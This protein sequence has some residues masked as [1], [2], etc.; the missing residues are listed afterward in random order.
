MEGINNSELVRRLLEIPV[1]REINNVLRNTTRPV[2]WKLAEQISQ[3]VAGSGIQSVRPTKAD[4]EEFAQACRIAELAV[5][6]QS[7]LGPVRGITNVRLLT[8][9]QWTE[10]NVNALKP[11]VE[12]LASRLSASAS[13][14]TPSPVQPVMDAIGPLVMGAQF[15]LTFGYL[16]HKALGTWDFGLPLEATRSVKGQMGQLNFNFSNIVRLEEELEIDPRQFRMWLALHDVTHELLFQAVNWAGPYFNS[17]VETYIDAAQVD[18]SELVAKVQ[19]FSDP[20]QLASLLQRPEDLL[21]ML[22]SP[23]QQ[24]VAERI[25]CFLSL[26]EGYSDWILKRGGLSLVQSFDRIR[27]GMSRRMAER[28]SPEKM[29]E[30]LFGLDLSNRNRRAGERFVGAIAEAGRLEVLWT[31]VENL[32]SADELS[33]PERWISRVGVA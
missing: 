14:D 30:K 20:Q 33:Q 3:A 31:K 19:S 10:L 23:I 1:I 5:V 27:E 21:P 18:A 15:G 8:R 12:R 4:A 2:D 13:P 29:L 17:L 7:G 25:E 6:G 24:S 32:P 11:L 26:T 28:S 16:S 9:P 22:R